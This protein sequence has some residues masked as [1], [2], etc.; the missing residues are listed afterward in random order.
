M[1]TVQSAELAWRSPARLRRCR[2]VLPDETRTGDVPQSAAKPASVLSRRD[3]EEVP[4]FLW[5]KRCNARG[6]APRTWRSGQQAVGSEEGAGQECVG[7]GRPEGGL[8]CGRVEASRVCRRHR[9]R[10]DPRRRSAP[11]GEG[12]RD[13][14]PGHLE[15]VVERRAAAS[16]H[17][18]FRRDGI[19]AGRTLHRD[20]PEIPIAPTESS[21]RERPRFS[22]SRGLAVQARGPKYWSASSGRGCTKSPSASAVSVSPSY[23][24]ARDMIRRPSTR[25]T[26]ARRTSSRNSGVGFR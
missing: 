19:P 16:A 22:A 8:S 5:R 1:T 3:H 13:R 21:A 18:P 25:S 14:H 7:P 11:A 26:R 2:F 9:R 4:P 24:S 6:G 10:R 15:L 23:I 17:L 12:R 20:A